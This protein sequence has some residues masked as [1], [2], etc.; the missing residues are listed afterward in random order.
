MEIVDLFENNLPII[1]VFAIIIFIAIIILKK[2]KKNEIT[3]KEFKP[4]PLKKTLDEDLKG[5]MKLFGIYCRKGSLFIG[6]NKIANFDK[7]FNIRGWFELMTWDPKGKE[8]TLPDK[9]IKSTDKNQKIQQKD[10]LKYDLL[11]IQ[12]KNKF[13]LLRWLGICKFFLILKMRDDN[14]VPCLRFDPINSSI[15]LNTGTDL[16]SWGKIWS[17]SM[18][19]IEYLNDISIKRLNEQAQMHME[20]MPDKV[21]HLEMEQAKKERSNK[22]FVEQEKSKYKERESAGDTTIT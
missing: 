2:H 3:F 6:F 1:M 9:P 17:N 14:E 19:A 15:I 5:K 13:F 7:Y 21:V 20:N 12:A 10:D 11:C 8:F 18:D 16:T 4:R 22:I